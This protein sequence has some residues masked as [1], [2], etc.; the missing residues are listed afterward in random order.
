MWAVR[1]ILDYI[2]AD[3]THVEHESRKGLSKGGQLMAYWHESFRR[4]TDTWHDRKLLQQLWDSGAAASRCGAG[5]SSGYLPQR[6]HRHG[7]VPAAGHEVSGLT[8]D[9]PGVRFRSAAAATHC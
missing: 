3:S 5:E 1:S 6:L 9:F 2:D 8:A 7:A 4:C